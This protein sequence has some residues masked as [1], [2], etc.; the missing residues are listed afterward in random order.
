MAR[1]DDVIDQRVKWFSHPIAFFLLR[2]RGGRF[3][4][5]CQRR[6]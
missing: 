4:S 3:E 1:G 2:L 5:D 6:E